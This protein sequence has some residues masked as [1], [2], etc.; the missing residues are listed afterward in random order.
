MYSRGVTMRGNTFTRARGS[1]S[2]GLLLKEILGGTIEGNTFA[3]NS[4]G[5]Y[6]EGSSR[7]A[8]RD[9]D[10]RG[11]GWAARVLADANDNAFTGNIFAANAF[12]V[13]TNS[14]TATSTFA[15][16]W[17]DEYRGYDLDADGTGDVPFHPVR[18]FSLVVEQHPE[19]LALLR[20]PMVAVLD[21]AER[22]LPVLTPAT[23]VDP[24]PLMRPPR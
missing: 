18:L 3:D 20:S 10:F 5:L 15:G 7:L 21:A 11:N 22:V 2:Y 1:A 24:R 6:L 13:T 19:A 12:D 17:W 23:M 9:N 14:R 4:T 16:N 8:I